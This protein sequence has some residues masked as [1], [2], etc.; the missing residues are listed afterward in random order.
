MYL[1]RVDIGES[2]LIQGFV[3][4]RWPSG[5][6]QATGRVVDWSR[7]FVRSASLWEQLRPLSI[8]LRLFLT[9]GEPLTSVHS[10]VVPERDEVRLRLVL[11]AFLRT[12]GMSGA[13]ADVPVTEQELAGAFT[14]VDETRFAIDY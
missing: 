9:A 13:E 12:S 4:V 2:R 7:F 11:A 3:R 10:F 1:P 5:D 8:G 6:H 14:H